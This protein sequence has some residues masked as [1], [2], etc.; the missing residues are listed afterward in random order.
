MHTSSERMSVRVLVIDTVEAGHRY[1]QWLHNGSFQTA[2][3]SVSIAPTV[4]DGLA[5]LQTTPPHILLINDTQ[6]R[7]RNFDDLLVLQQLH[8]QRL[9]TVLL[10]EQCDEDRMMQALDLGVSD[11]WI[12]GDLSPGMFRVRMRQLCDRWLSSAAAEPAH[13]LCWTTMLD[14]VGDGRWDWHIEDN[15]VVYSPPW[16][17][18]LGY[19]FHELNH[20]LTDWRDRIHPDDYDACWQAHQDYLQNPIGYFQHEYRLRCKDGQYKWIL[21]RGI[22]VE[23]TDDQRPCRMIG[24]HTDISYQ[25]QVEEQLRQQE[26][27]YR[28]LV[29]AI[30]DLLIRTHRNGW[31]VK[32]L[33]L[34]HTKVHPLTDETNHQWVR[35]CDFLPEPIVTERLALIDTALKTGQLQLQEYSFEENGERYYEEARIVPLFEEEA[36]VVVRDVSDRKRSENRLRAQAETLS[37]FYESSPIMMGVVELAETGDDILHLS[38][39]PATVEFLSLDNEQIGNCWASQLGVSHKYLEAWCSNYR[40]SQETRQP[41]WFEYEHPVAEESIW[42]SATVMFIGIADHGKPRFAYIAQDSSERK[43]AER[44]HQQHQKTEREL[45]LLESILEIIL[46]GYWDWDILSNQEYQSPRLKQMFGYE[47]HELLQERVTWQDLM[48]PEDIPIVMESFE[49]HVASR[50]KI[51]HRNEVR[52]RHRDGSTVWVLCSGQVIEWDAEGKPLRMV[53]CH[54][55]ISQLKQ[56][57]LANEQARQAAEEANQT[58]SRFLANMSHELRTPLNGILGYAQLLMQ[59]PTLPIAH[60]QSIAT[61][62]SSG[63]HLLQLI[64]EILDLARIE[65]GRIE[66]DL[67]PVAIA[68][69]VQSVGRLLQP[70]LAEHQL[71]YSVS[72]DP[73]QPWAIST[74][75]QKLRQVLINLVGNAIKFTDH[76]G[77]AI[78]V[79]VEPRHFR[80]DGTPAM[81]TFKVSDTGQGIEPEDLSRVF[82]AFEQSSQTTHYGGTGLGLA[83]SQQLVKFL[84]GDLQ[85]QSTPGQ[86][87]TFFFSIPAHI[88]TAEVSD[89]DPV[90]M[91]QLHL[92]PSQPTRRVLV[93]DDEKLNRQF[94][95]TML[96]EAGF[97]VV[98]AENGKEALDRLDHDAIDLVLM[99]LRM[100]GESGDRVT[101]HIRQHERQ[102]GRDRTPIIMVSA[103]AMKS[104][105]TLAL[106]AGCDAFLEKPVRVHTLL[107]AIAD[108]LDIRYTTVSVTA[109]STPNTFTSSTSPDLVSQIQAI[110]SKDWIDKLRLA[111]LRCHNGDIDQLIEQIPEQYSHLKQTLAD[112]SYNIQIENIL[113][114]TDQCL[115]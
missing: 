54:I 115:E 26:A 74:D 83:I 11:C 33:N 22:I 21:D 111:A 101:Q 49:R 40:L 7:D 105:R 16:A 73:P 47:E 18:M 68:P 109:N 61:I 35:L 103:S 17:E 89:L 90:D 79:T 84:G 50:G 46:A 6:L 43:Q 5:H 106:E 75:E 69:L 76:G 45:Q 95:Q 3:A 114:I 25:K 92:D 37:I 98:L 2:V 31:Q 65:S 12:V 44:L 82:N 23:W 71:T 27:T 94:F 55:D 64:N 48:F 67:S 62:F 15:I 8:A 80:S 93:V 38:A 107:S 97:E 34:N 77:I 86:G 108:Y 72:I 102:Q 96:S 99:D 14:A 19:A 39:N 29:D 81:V 32:A 4:A 113:A 56:A 1:Q 110:M 87:S 52:Y 41:V 20:H 30:P 58:K 24:I 66:L 57:E 10:M 53:G 42:L 85:V 51:P 70:K 60:Q 28:A 9:R 59:D 63:D 91:A 88:T 112:Y 13:G 100:P 36:L 104:D 78:S